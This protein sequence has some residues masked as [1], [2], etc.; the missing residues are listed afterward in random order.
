MNCNFTK[1]RTTVASYSFMLKLWLC[2]FFLCETQLIRFFVHFTSVFMTFFIVMTLLFII[3]NIIFHQLLTH[4]FFKSFKKCSTIFY[5][6]NCLDQ[7]LFVGVIAFIRMK[8]SGSQHN[9]FDPKSGVSV[10]Q[11]TC[12]A[13][14]YQVFFLGGGGGGGGLQ[15]GDH[16]GFAPFLEN[17]RNSLVTQTPSIKL[18]SL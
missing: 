12:L 13:F 2:N 17:P 9:S 16:W 14:F 5:C 7:K 18:S 8:T 1:K 15:W 10:S 4:R 6:D 11:N 3:L